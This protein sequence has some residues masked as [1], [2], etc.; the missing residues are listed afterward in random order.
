[1]PAE[2]TTSYDERTRLMT[3][4]VAI[5][6]FTIMLAGATAPAIR[7]AVGGRDGYRVMGLVMAVIITIGVVS[8]YVGPRSAPVSSPQPGAG[9]LR[10]QLR[11]VAGA[12]DFRWL[13]TCFVIQAL[14]TG[15]MLAGVD[16]L[17]QNVLDQDGAS[18]I[19]FI[20]FVG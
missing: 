11:I 12:R 3:W 15:C 9:G 18:T 5:L 20:C 6:A 1:M 4:R 2:M 8:S 17:A 7:D 16:Y 14:A 13:L 19:L 10:D